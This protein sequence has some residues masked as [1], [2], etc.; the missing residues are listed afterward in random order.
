MP[1]ASDPRVAVI[2]IG[3]SP[4]ELL[5]RC[6]AELRAQMAERN[7]AEMVVVAHASHQGCSFENVRSQF[8]EFTWVQASDALNVARLRGLGMAHSTAPVVA[9]LEG[10][11]I[12]GPGWLARLRDVDPVGALGGAIEPHDFRRALDWA[13]YFCEFGKFMA[14]L[15]SSPTQL[16]GTNVV[17]RRAAL[18]D[19]RRLAMDG[20][21][22]TFLN[23]SLGREALAAD[24][25]LIVR[26]ERTWRAWSALATRFHHGRVFAALRVRGLSVA[27]RAPYLA[28]ALLLPAV[29]VARV[30]GQ[31]LRRGRYVTRALA[32]MPWIAV[33]SASWAIGEL[34]GYAAG[35]GESLERWK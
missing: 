7:E 34:A 2:V 6:L 27:Q 5:A 24:A 9:F 4:P 19:A 22:E 30:L 29:L 17:Y 11:C 13:A 15:P 28:L 16:P 8:S 33:L 10:D 21:F 20:L 23:A 18:P 35:P 12:P 3:Y 32:A 31:P 25:T 1:S 26:H 14:P